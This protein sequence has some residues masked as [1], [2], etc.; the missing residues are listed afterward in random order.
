MPYNKSLD[1]TSRENLGRPI[2]VLEN[3]LSTRTYL[4]GERITLADLWTS[5]VLVIGFETV[6]D[7]A[8]RDK[9]PHLL[10]HYNTIRGNPTLKD[11]WSTTEWVETA[12]QWVPPPKAPKEDKAKAPKGEN[13]APKVYR[14]YLYWA[15]SSLILSCRQRPPSPRRKR[16]MGKRNPPFQLSLKPRTLSMTSQRAVLTWKNGSV[17]TLT[18]TRGVKV[19]VLSGFTRSSCY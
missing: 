11:I 10:R 6:I 7:Q 2:N 19:A 1:Q 16:T 17:H 12:K 4:V 13:A 8:W 14:H 18:W 9:L 3:Y 15:N 5:A